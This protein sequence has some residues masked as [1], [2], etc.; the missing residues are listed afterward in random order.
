MTLMNNKLK[1]SYPYRLHLLK[2]GK[3]HLIIQNSASS[4]KRRH[5]ELLKTGA[6]KIQGRAAIK[7]REDPKVQAIVFP[8]VVYH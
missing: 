1:V 4:V 8:F 5:K 6:V 7:A 3:I 2:S